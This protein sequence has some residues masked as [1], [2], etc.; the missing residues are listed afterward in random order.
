M[1]LTIYLATEKEMPTILYDIEKSNFNTNN[2]E[3]RE[4]PIKDLLTLPNIKSL[5]SDEGCG[6]GFRHS[7]FERN[8][9]IEVWN[10][11]EPPFD[12]INHESLVD[13]IREN[14]K[15]NSFVELLVLWNGDIYPV[16][17]K[18]VIKLDD[19]LAPSFF[20]KERGFYTVEL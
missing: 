12:N 19:I 9:W 6:C 14:N 11:G 5:G 3:D 4:M 13:F 20:F 15:E 18:E 8:S 17:S 7:L 1:C 16:E 10:E 2:I